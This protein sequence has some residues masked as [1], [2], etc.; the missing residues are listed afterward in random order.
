MLSR[1]TLLILALALLAAV[2]GGWL[3][4]RSRLAHVPPGVHVAGVGDPA[5]DLVL[6]DPAG[7]EHRL[8]DYRGR[9]VLLNFWATWCGPCL[10]EMP[11][12]AQAQ[13]AAGPGGA[14]IIG[15]AMDDPARVRAFLAAH[16]AGYPILLGRLDP[17]STSLRFGD[18]AE[19][20]PYSVLLDADGRVRATH[21]GPLDRTLLQAWLTPAQA[22][23]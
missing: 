14:R 10:D 7:R 23:R 15:I 9:R 4:H 6:P 12:L 22:T 21:R 17:P 11:A 2:L 3:Q 5:P 20:L 13:A 16:P 19:V 1:P 18:R 8:S